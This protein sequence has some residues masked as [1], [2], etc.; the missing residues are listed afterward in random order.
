MS[1]TATRLAAY[2]TAELK[3]L[4]ALEVGH[5]DRKLKQQTL[6]DIRTGIKELEAKLAAEQVA[7]L[8]QNGPRV[9]VAD[10]SQGLS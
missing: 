10:F 9:M 8:G 3:A 4:Q 6:N 5:G 1:D 2:K 7:A